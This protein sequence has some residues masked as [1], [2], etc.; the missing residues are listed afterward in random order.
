MVGRMQCQS[1]EESLCHLKDSLMTSRLNQSGIKVR[2]EMTRKEAAVNKK[3]TEAIARTK[4]SITTTKFSRINQC[5]F[6][7]TVNNR[8]AFSICCRFQNPQIQV[9]IK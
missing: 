2:T 7:S 8:Q 1:A 6:Y 3:T 5:I 4:K 9:K